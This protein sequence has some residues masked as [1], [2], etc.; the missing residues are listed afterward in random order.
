MGTGRF[1]A[2][3]PGV[4]FISQTRASRYLSDSTGRL[5]DNNVLLANAHYIAIMTL[6]AIW[7]SVFI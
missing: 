1:R 2:V 5:L 4:M 3:V 7:K 6:C